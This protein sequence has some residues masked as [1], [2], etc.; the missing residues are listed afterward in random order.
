M[1]FSQLLGSS[2]GYFFVGAVKRESDTVERLVLFFVDLLPKTR[3][4]NKIG[5]WRNR[6][7]I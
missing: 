5:G 1:F 7:A 4:T 2:L 3:L 6:V